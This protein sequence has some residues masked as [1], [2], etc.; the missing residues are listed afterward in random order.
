MS[1][2]I[3]IIPAGGS[4]QRMGLKQPKQFYELAGCPILVHTIR[5]FQNAPCI[6]EIIVVAPADYLD[7]VKAM[8]ATYGLDRVSQVV[9]GGATRQDSVR[10]GVNA[11]RAGTEYVAV[12]DGARPFV[13][14]ELIEACVA[15]AQ[16]TGAALAAVPVRDTLKTVA[17]EDLV[18][19]TVDRSVLWQAQTPQVVRLGLLQEAYRI[20]DADGFVGTDEASLL[21]HI[22]CPVR[23]V[24]GSE[25]NF[26]ITRPED[27][28]IAEALLMTDSKQGIANA[29]RVGH[30]YDAHRLVADRL[31]ILGG[32]TIPHSLGLLGH[33]D[34][35]V[36][37]HALCD[38]VLGAIGEGDIGRHFPDT[39]PQYKGADS[40]K[41]L[42]RVME[43]AAEK[44]YQLGNAD[45]T[46]IAQKPKLAPHFP[47]MREKLAKACEV[48]EAMINLKGTTT[49]KMGFAGR[50]EG[51]AAHA[52]VSML[53]ISG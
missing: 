20:T 2:T 30:G 24:E 16:E 28:R 27:L 48:G 36:L 37:T 34:A 25:R 52:I 13:A 11:V 42:A 35:D 14:P 50:E 40:L 26:K 23:V 18:V 49:E 8:V 32:V 53:P 9:V 6:N 39:D 47:A 31:L 21:E 51:I 22:D 4:G 41:L 12:H 29:P 38:A 45:I 1:K 46:V 33:S 5:A 15:K 10:A 43:I 3:A 19:N 7:E 44:G 17:D